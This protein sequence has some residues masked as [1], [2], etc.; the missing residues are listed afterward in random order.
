[1][2]IVA[3]FGKQRPL[4]DIGPDDFGKLRKRM[5]KKW[6]PQRLNKNIQFVRCVFK[7]AFEARLIPLPMHFGPEFKRPSKKTMRLHRAK[8]GKKLFTAEEVRRTLEASSPQLT[9]MILLGINAGFGNADCGTLPQR[10]LD[11]VGGW[12]NFPRPKTGIERRC[13][14]W[15]ETVAAIRAALGA[16]PEAKKPEHADLVFIT[17]CGDS[18]HTGTP[19][20][21]LSRE[22]G[23][24]LRKLGIN[25]RTGLGFYTLRHTFRTV[26]AK[27]NDPLATN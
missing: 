19:D 20:G 27:A 16:R 15:P 21:P 11:L 9:T 2:E 23:K 22:F 17:R 13:P 26:A 1:D 12:A 3:A 24:L 5:A 4:S 7:Y 25:G 10:A 6:G 18:W 14:L 8:Q